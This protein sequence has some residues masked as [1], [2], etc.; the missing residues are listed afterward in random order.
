MER[1]LTRK[2][3]HVSHKFQCC[4]QGRFHGRV[5][6]QT[7]FNLC[8]EELGNCREEG[9]FN[10]EISQVIACDSISDNNQQG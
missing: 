3:L 2:R 1:K 5:L 4:D 7:V 9:D 10:L 6:C 8:N